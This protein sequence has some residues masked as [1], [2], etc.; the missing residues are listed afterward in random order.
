VTYSIQKLYYTIS[1]SEQLHACI[2]FLLCPYTFTSNNEKLNQKLL[3]Q[4]YV[5]RVPQS[6]FPTS[7]NINLENNNKFK[8]ITH[9]KKAAIKKVVFL[10]HAYS[11]HFSHFYTCH[12]SSMLLMQKIPNHNN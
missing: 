11:A 7:H 10:Y 9:F 6:K 8:I 5:L 12:H 4:K 1:T 3:Q 2:L